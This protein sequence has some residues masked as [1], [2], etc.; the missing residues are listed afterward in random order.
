MPGPQYYQY[1]EPQRP[2]LEQ[3]SR[4]QQLLLEAQQ[5]IIELQRKVN[6]LENVKEW[7]NREPEK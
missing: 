1:V 4:L 5:T 6:A 3:F 7:I 2:T